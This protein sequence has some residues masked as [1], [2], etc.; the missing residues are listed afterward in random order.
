MKRF[1]TLPGLMNPRTARSILAATVGIVIFLMSSKLAY[2]QI[3]LPIFDPEEETKNKIKGIAFE[4]AKQTNDFKHGNLLL[5]T[6]KDNTKLVGRLVWV[7]RKNNRLY[8]RRAAG[9]PPLAV[10]EKQILKVEKGVKEAKGKNG[11]VPAAAKREVVNEP[12]IFRITE[13]NGSLVTVRYIAPDLSP[14]EK[15][16]LKDMEA[17]ENNAARKQFMMSQL[18]HAI[19]DQAETLRYRQLIASKQYEMMSTYTQEQAWLSS[20]SP[21]Q[22]G[23]DIYGV[24][25]GGVRPDTLFSQSYAST[26]GI[27]GGG[28]SVTSLAADMTSLMANEPTLA[29][30][31]AKANQTLT[32][33]R[34]R[35]VFE[36]G[37][38]IAVQPA[39]EPAV[40]PAVNKGQ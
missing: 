27:M 15:T 6:L 12:E 3:K 10:D 30:D 38:L 21:Y 25:F 16:Q 4:E 18:L 2:A 5:V 22:P 35:G 1:E 23:Y 34:G 11:I 14:G 33:S 19:G 9:M 7:D 17:A 24:P 31:L 37:E 13:I 28:S 40:V 32:T 29:A 20:Y 39:S 36:G 8:L 26:G